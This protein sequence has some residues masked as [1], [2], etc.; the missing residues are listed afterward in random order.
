MWLPVAVLLTRTCQ[1]R[2]DYCYQ[3]FIPEHDWPEGS[4]AV[5][6]FV[7]TDEQPTIALHHCHANTLNR[8]RRRTTVGFYSL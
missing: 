6:L 3:S 2:T 7:A 1:H 8:T 5:K 4:K